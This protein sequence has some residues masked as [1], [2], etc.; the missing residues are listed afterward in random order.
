MSMLKSSTPFS[1]QSGFTLIELVVVIIILGVLAVV[2]APKFINLKTDA[3]I[4]V[5]KGATGSMK[6]AVLLFKTKNAHIRKFIN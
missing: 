6:T 2:A 5:I 3:H 4:A 1:R